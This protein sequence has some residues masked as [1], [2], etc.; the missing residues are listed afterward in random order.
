[1]NRRK[2]REIATRL[3]FEISI[4]KES[5]VDIIENFRENTEEKIEDIDFEYVIR[6]LKGVSENEAQINETISKYLVKWKLERLPKM[7]LAILKMATYEILFDEDIPNKVT[8]NEAIELAKRYGDD[9]A[10]SFINGV[11]N[12]LIKK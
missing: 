8:I 4:N 9:N 6:V 12:N 3:I 10:P 7:N 2:S 5:Y 1:M 11:L